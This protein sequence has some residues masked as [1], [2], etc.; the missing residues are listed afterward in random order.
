MSL[1]DFIP[2]C[3]VVFEQLRMECDRFRGEEFFHVI[4]ILSELIV[5]VGKDE[6]R[7]F[8]DEVECRG[9]LATRFNLRHGFWSS[10]LDFSRSNMSDAFVNA[11]DVVER[12]EDSIDVDSLPFNEC[13]PL[14]AG[15]ACWGT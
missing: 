8:D 6:R 10:K 3:F 4:A 9:P 13:I 5:A 12:T 11:M 15:K 7:W 14:C 2:N 1:S